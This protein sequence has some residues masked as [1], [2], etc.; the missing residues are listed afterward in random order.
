MPLR[1]NRVRTSRYMRATSGVPALRELVSGLASQTGPGRIVPSASRVGRPPSETR[2]H[3]SRFGEPDL[4]MGRGEPPTNP[5]NSPPH[6]RCRTERRQ[7]DLAYSRVSSAARR[8]AIRAI[9]RTGPVGRTR[10]D[11]Q[12]TFWIFIKHRICRKSV[13]RPRATSPWVRPRPA[14]RSRPTRR[15]PGRRGLPERLTG[16]S[17]PRRCQT[18]RTREPRTQSGP[19]KPADHAGIQQAR[20]GELRPAGLL[21]SAP[22]P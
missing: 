5:A 10:V 12:E 20:L 16:A 18:V 19:M 17:I 7:G 3:H 11:F 4:C 9:G 22:A 14:I 1:A 6:Y 8:I 13:W 15:D 21:T 2:V